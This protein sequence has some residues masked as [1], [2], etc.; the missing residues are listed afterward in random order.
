[1]Q[2]TPGRH[3]HYTSLTSARMFG[4]GKGGRKL[5]EVCGC[6]RG[7]REEQWEEGREDKRSDE[8]ET[9]LRTAGVV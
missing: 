1:M 3:M 7:V 6:M 2:P 8:I 5:S 4:V 9:A